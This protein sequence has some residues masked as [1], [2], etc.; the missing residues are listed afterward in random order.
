MKKGGKGGNPAHG[1]LRANFFIALI[2]GLNPVQKDG[3]D[4][5]KTQSISDDRWSNTVQP[6]SSEIKKIWRPV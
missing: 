2:E 1:V 4:Q 5:P 3:K 6:V